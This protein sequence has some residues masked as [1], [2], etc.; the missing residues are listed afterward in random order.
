ME[1]DLEV[2]HNSEDVLCRPSKRCVRMAQANKGEDDEK[3]KVV[4]LTTRNGI[5]EKEKDAAEEKAG[6]L[7]TRLGDEIVS[8]EKITSTFLHHARRT[9]DDVYLDEVMYGGVVIQNQAVLDELLKHA[10]KRTQF[11]I[12]NQ[13]MGGD[14]WPDVKKTFTAVYAIGKKG[15]FRYVSQMEGQKVRF[16]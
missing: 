11:T 1:N 15:P 14:T 9:R 5:L 7:E 4:D 8:R 13:L 10:A 16:E 12:T 3:A 2:V 6:D